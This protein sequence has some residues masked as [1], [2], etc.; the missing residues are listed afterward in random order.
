MIE[1]TFMIDNQS[2]TLQEYYSFVFGMFHGVHLNLDRK[3][4]D[5]DFNNAETIL[6]DHAVL[7]GLF[8]GIYVNVFKTVV[9]F[10]KSNYSISG[11]SLLNHLL[12]TSCCSNSHQIYVQ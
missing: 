7:F 10:R 2:Q 6:I 8:L 3:K 12:V 5:F 11:C 4:M 1:C 9:I